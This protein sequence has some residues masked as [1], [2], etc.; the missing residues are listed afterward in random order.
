MLRHV[1]RAGARDQAALDSLPRQGQGSAGHSEPDD[2]QSAVSNQ[3]HS[4]IVG[5]TSGETSG[6]EVSGYRSAVAEAD[7]TGV[8]E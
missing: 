3:K 6:R 5:A 2:L 1:P 8:A 7:R 4:T